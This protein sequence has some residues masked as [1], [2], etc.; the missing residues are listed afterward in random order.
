MSE[1]YEYLANDRSTWRVH[2]APEFPHWFQEALNR[3][4][5]MNRHGKPNLRLVWGGTC[6]SEKA[7]EK[8]RLK[9]LC[10]MSPQNLVGYE[11]VLDGERHQ[12]KTI[13]EAPAN[14]MIAPVTQRDQLG[15]LRWIIEV[16]TSPEALEAS[17]RFTQSYLPGEIKPI[18]REFPREG[19]YDVLFVVAN[20][21]DK[22]RS[23]GNDLL[24]VVQ[25]MW[26]ERQRPFD[27]LEAN[28]AKHE[29]NETDRIAKEEAEFDRAM[30]QGD[31]KLDKEEKERRAE[32]WAK[33]DY[34]LDTTGTFM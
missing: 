9:Y 10:G 1:T 3:I 22:Y 33:H 27:E 20:R 18:L 32:Y 24:E 28:V 31:L 16:W 25:A 30:W 5:G 23:V 4:G 26:K 15:L 21:E 14:A 34:S 29:S 2:R 12:V 17:Q 8:G 11:Y 6:E 13:E 7:A 19:V